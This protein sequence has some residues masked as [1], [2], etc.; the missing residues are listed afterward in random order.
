MNVKVN[1]SIEKT[2]NNYIIKEFIFNMKNFNAFSE[3][4]LVTLSPKSDAVAP[5]EACPCQQKDMLSQTADDVL[6]NLGGDVVQPTDGIGEYGDIQADG[7]GE[8]ADGIGEYAEEGEEGDVDLEC[9]DDGLRVKFNGVEIVLPKNVVEKIKD[10]MEH[11]ETETPAEEEDEHTENESEDEDSDVTE[12]ED[13][14]EDAD[15]EDADEEDEDDNVFESFKAK[16]Y[17]K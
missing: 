7:I 6:K 17:K 10:H 4:L 15:E 8:Y 16:N 12:P 5:V 3:A 13:T 11:E 9:T 14:Q 1:L 2:I